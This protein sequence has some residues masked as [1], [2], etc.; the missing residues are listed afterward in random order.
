MNVQTVPLDRLR[1]DPRNARKHGERNLAEIGDSLDRFGQQLPLVVGSDHVV[2]VG[3]GRLAAMRRLGWTEA[4]VVVSDL[5][6]AELRAYAIADNHTAATSEWDADV[7][8][9]MRDAGDDLGSVGFTGEELDALLESAAGP[10]VATAAPRAAKTPKGLPIRLTA[11]QRAAMDE[12]FEKFRL[13]HGD[14]PAM[15]E[16]QIVTLLAYDWFGGA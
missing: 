13:V 3:S 10:A 9:A 5:P 11:E 7:L 16:G 8:G 12:V 6:L 1:P 2:R 15:T 14:G 4:A